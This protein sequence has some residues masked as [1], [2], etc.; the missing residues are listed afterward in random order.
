MILEHR[1]DLDSFTE[2][3]WV[4]VNQGV[5]GKVDKLTAFIF[6]DTHP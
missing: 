5:S 3:S 1:Q 2:M 6:F 4:K